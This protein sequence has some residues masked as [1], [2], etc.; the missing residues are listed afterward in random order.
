MTK[1]EQLVIKKNRL[2]GKWIF[3]T[4]KEYSETVSFGEYFKASMAIATQRNSVFVI[5]DETRI[6]HGIGRGGIR[7][8][9]SPRNQKYGNKEFIIFPYKV[10]NHTV[11]N[12]EEHDFKQK[13]PGVYAYLEEKREELDKRDADKAA[14]WF[15][16]GRSQAVQNMNK[17]K[18]LVSTVVTNEVNVYE[19]SNRAVPYA[20]I[21]IISDNGYDLKIA[22]RILESDEFLKYIKGIGTPASGS[23]LRITANDINKFKF[24]LDNY[25]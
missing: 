11:I 14:Q 17:R 21:Y 23:S 8:A 15:E 16:Y 18:L 19:V 2:H 22:K 13:Y 4:A 25:L 20:G 3:D 6:K 12:Y 10:R 7:P 24:I 1:R 9:V 5:D